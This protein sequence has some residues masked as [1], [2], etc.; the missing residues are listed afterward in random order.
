MGRGTI[1]APPK[2]VN[3]SRAALGVAAIVPAGRRWRR[4]RLLTS[5]H[6]PW[7]TRA[8]EARD[9]RALG[10][11]WRPSAADSRSPRAASS[12]AMSGPN[13]LPRRGATPAR[14]TEVRNAYPCHV[15]PR[16]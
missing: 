11:A 14:R 2:G 3:G 9:P 16:A 7:S 12:L 6:R 15:A 1:A 10:C 4:A 8:M 5:E 13:R